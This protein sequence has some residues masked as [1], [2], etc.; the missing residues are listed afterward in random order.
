LASD[1]VVAPI[2]PEESTWTFTE[3]LRRQAAAHPN[4]VAYTFLNERDPEGS[5]IR[6][7]ELEKKALAV[8]AFL[9]SSVAPGER[10][11]LLLPSG[12]DYIVTFFGC[13]CAGVIAVP[14]FPPHTGRG[15]HGEHWFQ[16]VAR[17]AKPRLAF[18]APELAGTL[19]GEWMLEAGIRMVSPGE[20]DGATETEWHPPKIDADTIAFLQYTSGST[21]QP[22][23]VMVSH[24]NLMHNMRVIREACGNDQESTVVSWLPLHHD[25]GLI[26]TVLHPA[27]LGARSV[28]MSPARFLHNPV[29]W[30]QAITR[31]RGKSSS[32]PN[33]AYD[34]CARK[35]KAEQ[36][37][38][39][40]L[41][42]WRIAVNGAE[43]VRF[44]TMDRFT[45]AFAECGFNREAFRP[46]YGLAEA[47]LMVTGARATPLP[48]VKRFSVEGL[49]RNRVCEPAG[50]GD[51]RV[52]VGC[53][54]ALPGHQVRLVDPETR[55]PCAENEI[56]EIWVSGPSVT[57]GYWNRPQESEST[58]RAGLF[59]EEQGPFLR[60][61]DLGFLFIGQLFITGRRKNLIIVRGRNLYPQDIE[62]TA[63]QAD[64]SL[65]PDAGAAFVMGS[66]EEENVALVCEIERHAKSDPEKIMAAVREAV[67]LEHGISLHT[68]AL[69]RNGT[70]PRTTS[71]KV[72]HSAAQELFL[73][74]TLAIVAQSVLRQDADGPRPSAA[75][76]SRDE[77]L[78]AEPALRYELIQNALRDRA[79]EVLKI[80]VDG[81]P[82]DH[83]LLALGLDSLM[84]SEFKAWIDAGFG[85][86]LNTVELLEG[87]TVAG[88]AAKI[89]DHLAAETKT[90]S[91][92]QE[93]PS[94][95]VHPLSYGQRGLWVLH[96]V[97]PDSTAYTLFS[98][99]RTRGSLDV[100]ALRAAFQELMA[101]QPMLRTIFTSHEGSVYQTILAPEVIQPERH[102]EYRDLSASTSTD[103]SGLLN[104][105]ARK[106]FSLDREPPIRFLL[107]RLAASEHA[108]MLMLH[109]IIA[110]LVSLENIFQEF[111][112]LYEIHR[113]AK[114]PRAEKG[115]SFLEFVRWQAAL[116]ESEEGQKQFQ[117]WRTTLAGE[118]PVLEIPG[119]RPRL[120][121]PTFRGASF[122][123]QLDP[124]L[125]RQLEAV[126]QQAHATV[127]MALA[128]IF[129]LLLH[130]VTGQRDLLLG[131]PAS[132]RTRT[133]FVK[134]I[135]YC[136]NPI[137]LR[138]QYNAGT[139]FIGYLEEV[140]RGALE[141]FANQ[142]FPFPL[143]VEKLHPARGSGISPIFQVMFVWQ[144]IR[145]GWGKAL[146]AMS[147][148]VPGVR[149]QLADLEL[150]SIALENTGSQF[151]ITLM[152]SPTMQGFSGTF[153][154]NSDLFDEATIKGLARQ[155]SV[156]SEEVT[157]HPVRALAAF[158]LLG[159]AERTQLLAAPGVAAH[160]IGLSAGSVLEMFVE[161]AGK[162]PS[163]TALIAGA[164]K[165]TY[166]QL[167]ARSNQFARYLRNLGVGSEVRVGLCLNRSA[168]MIIALL[169]VWKAGGAYIPL[170]PQD[171]ADR[172]AVL[173]EQSGMKII[174]AH[175]DLVGQMPAKLPQLVLLNLDLDLIALEEESNLEV[176]IEGSTLAYV[177]YT[178]GSTGLPKGV[179]IEH[180]SLLNLLAGLRHAI[181]NDHPDRQLRVSVNAPLAFDSS[182]KQI[183]TLVMGHTLCIVPE[184]LRRN[185]E[186]LL[187][188][189]EES[190]LQVLD[191]TPTQAQMI[192]ESGLAQKS[193][194]LMLLLGGE[195]VPTESWEALSKAHS[196][197]CYNLYGPT[198]CT[199]DVT[200]CRLDSHPTPSLGRPLP[201]T[202][203]YILGP[204]LEPVPAGVAGEIC[205]GGFNVG[206]GYLDNPR[207]TAEKFL[208]D[209]FS[210]TP[211]A[212]MYRSGD[213]GRFTDDGTIE[214]M[215][216]VDRQ[217]KV[218]GF[219]IEL[220][221]IEAVLAQ[222]P[223]V[224]DSAVVLQNDT[225][226]YHRLIG[227]VVANEEA[228]SNTYREF[229]AKRLPEYMVP[230][231]VVRI[232]RMPVNS[233]G[234]RNY[235]AL[236]WPETSSLDIGPDHIPP[237][238]SLEKYLVTLWSRMLKVEPI[239]IHDNF[240]SLGGDSLQ[241]T[242]LITQVQQDYPTGMPLLAL[243]FQQPTI[244]ALSLHIATGRADK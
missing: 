85:C 1:Q 207:L 209:P 10:A 79:A 219:R 129:Q 83:P 110:D 126:A 50:D 65:R 13:L 9:S 87:A 158:P 190:G 67:L 76:P 18:C 156:L 115:A 143:L 16:T 88:L 241:A 31:F 96:R 195:A 77:I 242:R 222:Y 244:A 26:G 71:G 166:E 163:A 148:G 132:G 216:R 230:S 147:M 69:L 74:G 80:N 97:A 157:N 44:D 220:G 214:F 102:F 189:V 107:T 25:M 45:A 15:R 164:E 171:P 105:E 138:S 54:D 68:V 104:E 153:K 226:G 64:S 235:T 32:A 160:S 78:Q 176:P 181:Y 187:A 155:F 46:S 36:K 89:L 118:L 223:G 108:L 70:I 41:S 59:P 234:K 201:G 134:T 167:N 212:R 47:T 29:A 120:M 34:L 86:S 139:S 8:A 180:R 56:G 149:F 221:E 205:I 113:G 174:I 202:S 196:G 2:I 184:E 231:V 111:E 227:Y 182:I 95:S 233:N 94:T 137:V 162:T 30:L 101:R 84:A 52:L 215:G 213:R 117:Y 114:T 224:A 37:A 103:L 236:P 188:Y 93:R 5:D 81:I 7:A 127:F 161:Q 62:L 121:E 165:I 204:W 140:R 40:D 228:P 179:M 14:G 73:K 193:P 152:M 135:G 198:E 12:L 92:Q 128:A 43:P 232:P 211:G 146:A 168:E 38:G 106:P 112:Q 238:T 150:D 144:G 82:Y 27:Y 218:R 33:F 72:R 130:R 3:V 124:G 136:V 49:E 200:C 178:S 75:Q 19:P 100:S 203:I 194:N 154:Y 123:F 239:G 208:P 186:A 51:A 185:G 183:L 175:E 206:R 159:N 24:Q 21:S 48:A 145:S 22:K 197:R 66:G 61:G 177:I 90:E 55:K 42:T 173:I 122:P 57:R 237:Q 6:F 4:R 11:L 172:L 191:C 169:G 125:A 217:V 240:F 119:A 142:D 109:H 23:G 28:L 199:V 131:T 141:A 17:D 39:L 58:F 99:A 91:P 192:I 98:A 133:A 229:L 170:N 151:D 60:T 35:I 53:G 210:G 63:L 20:I 225:G 243:F 116:V